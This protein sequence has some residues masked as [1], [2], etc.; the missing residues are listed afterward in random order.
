ML[1][2]SEGLHSSNNLFRLPSALVRTVGKVY[3]FPGFQR[4]G[5]KAKYVARGL[6]T[7][8]L[9]CEWFT[10]LAQ[11][12]MEIICRIQ[13]RLFSK[14][15]RP[16]L[17]K[18]LAPSDALAALKSHYGFVLNHFTPEALEKIYRARTHRLVVWEVPD[19]GTFS[20]RI[21]NRQTYE[22]EGDLTL[23]LYEDN[24]NRS[25]FAL[26]FTLWRNAVD[27]REIFIGGLQGVQHHDQGDVIV[28]V[29]R[30]MNG[31]RPKA[32]LLFVAQQIAEHWEVK[33]IRAVSDAKNIFRHLRLRHKKFVAS[34]DE[35]W[36]ESDGQMDT[37][38]FFTLPTRFIPRPIAEIKQNKRSL[39]KRRY[40]MLES[41]SSQIKNNLCALKKYP[42]VKN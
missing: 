5:D 38:G 1:S 29:T 25:L 6:L 7:P 34:Y 20:V 9:T 19:F 31:L 26:T 23:A 37:D 27:N 14:L 13:P 39:Y 21:V 40:A 24:R 2:A 4:F 12:E 30:G 10:L 3:P 16:Y 22:K 28:G 41:F 8:Q 15:Q 35:F 32:L 17:H 11:P 36:L 42:L 33:T 18:D